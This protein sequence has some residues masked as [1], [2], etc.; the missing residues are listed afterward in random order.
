MRVGKKGFYDTAFRLCAQCFRR[1]HTQK[2]APVPRPLGFGG[3]DGLPVWDT[4]EAVY[5]LIAGFSAGVVLGFLFPSLWRS[6]RRRFRNTRRFGVAS[7]ENDVKSP[8][9]VLVDPVED[10]GEAFLS[11]SVEVE[12]LF[13]RAR[14]LVHVGKVREA[15]QAYLNILGDERVSKGETNRALFE[16]AQCYELMGL[17]SRA[18][19]TAL[20]LLGRKPKLRPVFE[21]TL[22]LLASMHRFERID[23]LLNLWKGEADSRLR[24]RIAHALCEHAEVLLR[25]GRLAEA[26]EYGIRAVRWSLMSARARILVWQATSEE[27]SQRVGANAGQQW[28]AL[29]VDLEARVRIHLETGVSPAGGAD[30]LR[31]LLASF[32]K[33]DDFLEVFSDYEKEFRSVSRMDS[34]EKGTSAIVDELLFHVVISEFRGWSSEAAE[35]FLP[36][37]GLISPALLA[38]VA[39]VSRSLGTSV[40]DLFQ[41][42]MRVHKC[43]A[44]GA[45][46][47]VFAWRCPH[48]GE[49]E[50]LVSQAG[51][52]WAGQ[53]SSAL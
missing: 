1:D 20:E 31:G 34:P 37:V 13:V 5:F 2:G 7:F 12:V 43:R 35:R 16:L 39:E 48:C 22:D 14:G 50:S 8:V 47:L 38:R 29:A 15:V 27:V 25:A 40:A 44:C 18:F 19:E 49:R 3:Q 4:V 10:Q 23:D 52:L 24:L 11:S 6:F 30:Y 36:A 26:R 33:V 46:A 53:K 42:N 21:F 45:A 9:R 17:A 41:K 32:S 28:I 51:G